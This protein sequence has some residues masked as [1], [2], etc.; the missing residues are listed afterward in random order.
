MH[1][2]L[3]GRPEYL[4]NFCHTAMMFSG[5][6]PDHDQHHRHHCSSVA[7]AIAMCRPISVFHPKFLHHRDKSICRFGCSPF[8]TQCVGQI[9]LFHLKF[10]QK[11]S[12]ICFFSVPD[13]GVISTVFLGYIVF[14]P[15]NYSTPP[16]PDQIWRNLWGNGGYG[17]QNIGKTF[18]TPQ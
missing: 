12:Q 11:Y 8:P 2:S 5:C 3:P 17:G 16:H 4:P 10:L 1:K 14:T 15:N 13:G 18:V 6:L 9:S 7:L